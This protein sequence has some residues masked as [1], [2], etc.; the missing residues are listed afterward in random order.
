[1][2]NAASIVV[3]LQ[4]WQYQNLLFHSLDRGRRLCISEYADVYII[5]CWTLHQNVEKISAL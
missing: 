2:T 1:M 4:F 5:P 3:K